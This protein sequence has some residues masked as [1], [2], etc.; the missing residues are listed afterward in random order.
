MSDQIPPS[1]VQGEKQRMVNDLI[2][3][4]LR[5][6]SLD[7]KEKRKLIDELRKASPAINDRWLYRWVVWSLGAVAFASVIGFIVLAA[8]EKTIPQGLVALGSG[9]IGGLAGLSTASSRA[10]SGDPADQT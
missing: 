9:A 6:E 10:R 7:A 4:V 3:V 5:N 8:L 1:T 2:D